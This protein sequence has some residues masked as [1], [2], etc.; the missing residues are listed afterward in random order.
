MNVI[1]DVSVAIKWFIPENFYLNARQLLVSKPTLIAPSFILPELGN[2]LWKKAIR[3][4][5]TKIEASQIF[6]L[7]QSRLFTFV[8]TTPLMGLS[9]E[10][11]LDLKHPVY[12]CF[13]LAAAKMN[14]CPLITADKDFF[15]KVNKSPW[16]S[17]IQWIE[18]SS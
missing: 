14:K 12:D 13:Y 5:I 2:I 17:N 3:A 7:C 8:S 15:I 9:F 1:V 11:A 18:T 4:E 6:N 16:E 10:M